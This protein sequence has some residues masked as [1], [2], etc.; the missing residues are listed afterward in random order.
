[1]RIKT[2]LGPQ[3]QTAWY[4][5]KVF[6]NE[7]PL[8]D[9]SSHLP[10]FSRESFGEGNDT[11][12]YLQ[13]IVRQPLGK[14]ERKIP[15]AT[16]SKRYALIQHAEVCNW[17]AEGLRALDY[18]SDN[19]P[20]ETLMSEY[21]ERLHLSVHVQKFDFDPGDKEKLS[22]MLE[23]R[24]SVDRS[25]AFEIRLRWQRLVCSNGMWVQEEDVLRKIH[26][27]DWMNRANVGDF[28]NER[29][30]L[31]SGYQE[32]LQLWH[33]IEVS[34]EKIEE[35]ADSILTR[36]W[37]VQLAARCCHIARSGYDGI[38]GSAKAK[39]PA[40]YYSVSSDK[41]V[42]GA[43]APISNLYHLSQVLTWLADHRTSIEDSDKKT[44]DIPNLL[45]HFVKKIVA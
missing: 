37:G 6:K 7:Y 20:V 43:F 12:D 10:E 25:C 22:L 26:H 1:V 19:V 5:Q 34:I 29:V 17:L 24:N 13:T 36:K 3:I 4:G 27:I 18:Y 14:D 8:K 23:A 42:P 16:V 2:K 39:T 44:S 32:M 21:G 28:I 33:T 11:N 35:W 45:E 15:V 31:F 41:K 9:L 40:S 38:V 30:E